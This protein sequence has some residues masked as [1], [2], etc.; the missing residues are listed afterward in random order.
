[1]QDAGQCLKGLAK[2]C[3]ISSALAL[4][5]PQSCTKLSILNNLRVLLILPWIYNNN[6]DVNG[7]TSDKLSLYQFHFHE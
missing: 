3:G 2:D 6:G 5:I 1:M 4:E 7:N